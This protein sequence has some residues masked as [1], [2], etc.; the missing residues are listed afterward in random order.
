MIHRYVFHRG[1]KG[2]SFL[3]ERLDGAQAYDRIA[4]YF[5]SSLLEFA[6]E[7]FDSVE[8]RIRI[9][10]NSRLSAADV[11]AAQ[12]VEQEQKRDF[13]RHDPADLSTRGRDKLERLYGLLSSRRLEVRVLPD[14]SFGMIHGKAGVITKADGTRTSFLGSTNETL[15]GWNFN[16]ELVWEDDSKEACEW[17]QREFL[18]LWN[19]PNARGLSD[20]VVK[21]IQRLTDRIELDLE[22]WKEG[23]KPAGLVVE[24][25]VYR[26]EFGLWP[27]QRDFV[28]QAWKAHQSYG[29]RFVLADQVG[30]GK[31]IQLAMVAQLAALTG[32]GPVLAI[33]P[34]T[35]MEQWQTE[36]WDLME[37]PT[38]RWTGRVWVD[39]EGIEHPPI[40]KTPIGRSPRRIALISQG[41]VIRNQ[42]VGEFLLSREWEL[43]IADEA[44]RAR[45]RKIPK[46]EESGTHMQNIS[47]EANKLYAFLFR[48]AS[49]TRSMLLSTA[50]PVQLH[51]IEG[52]DL[53]RILAEGNEHVLGGSGSHWRKPDEALPYLMEN[54]TPPNDPHT[55]WDWL[56]NPLPPRWEAHNFNYFRMKL[57]LPDSQAVVTGNERVFSHLP[58]D[59]KARM[60]NAAQDL[61]ERH[62]PFLRHII[63]RTREYLEHHVNPATNEPYLQ[64]IEVELFDDEPVYLESY[65]RQGYENAEQFCKMLE[66][67]V[68]GAGFFKTML[69]RRVGSSIQAGLSTVEK[70]LREWDTSKA[71][72]HTLTTVGAENEED[73]DEEGDEEDDDYGLD[74]NLSD[75][76]RR[77]IRSLQPAEID[78]LQAVRDHLTLGLNQRSGADPKLDT[79]M[80]YLDSEGWANEGVVL[81]SQYYD[82]ALWIGKR[83]AA[84]FP[85]YPTA[86]Y[87]GAA[88][89][90]L[91][92][93]GRFLRRD[94]EQIKQMVRS[95]DIRILIGTDAASEGL[96]LQQ[97]RNL[98]N[99]D[100][101]WNPTRLE[102]RKG[103]VQRIGQMYGSIR[104]LN[105]R[106]K[107]SVEDK[108]HETLS[109]RLRAISD[110]FGQI[111]DVLRDV[112]V[113]AALRDLESAKT[114]LDQ[115]AKKNP[116]SERYSKMDAVPSWE[117][118]PEVVNRV[119]KI[120][121]LKRPW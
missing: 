33:L 101:P 2:T 111:P 42:E 30:L 49:K 9:V 107:D 50:T 38:A 82:T 120:D 39:E 59:L 99:I 58:P 66:R 24:A 15:S 6:G 89:S 115:L 112:W 55:L 100:L 110:L 16:Y 79:I 106:Y 91:W 97:L 13:L 102:Q 48:I 56:R 104:I 73:I 5:D 114:R 75:T 37:I 63:R 67:R 47:T 44:H 31:T 94:R 41:L 65:L 27:H 71:R 10:C 72:E 69:L 34:K 52:W 86:L 83:I 57:E 118:W 80:R 85:A 62:H 1:A 53:L 76:D 26:E 28:D 108:V 12:R 43:V 88:K 93:N 119:E 29:A 25:P 46:L 78:L 21:E 35:L 7:A 51:P 92:Q 20:A 70:M 17:V 4:G 18:R 23:G 64:K 61:F 22:K 19:H 109:D 84:D 87:A 54:A 45:R 40:G 95:G 113:E 74:D 103:R 60:G 96:N 68:K 14:E 116:F 121:A 11:L 77:E 36:L 117:T 8:G 81:F 3:P 32:H 90:G 105:L 98:I